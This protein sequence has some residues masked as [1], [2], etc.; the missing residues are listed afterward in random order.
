MTKTK[1]RLYSLYGDTVEVEF[2]YDEPFD[3][4]FGEYPDFDEHPRTTP[5]GRPWVNATKDDCPLADREYGDC[6]SCEFYKCER[7]GDLIGVCENEQ[8]RKEEK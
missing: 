5:C 4:Y 8:L 1:N 6:G 2:I 3:R 7:P